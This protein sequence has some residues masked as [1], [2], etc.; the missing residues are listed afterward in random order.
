MAADDWPKL[1]CGVR[2]R[3]DVKARLRLDFVSGF[4][5]AFDHDDALQPRPIMT[6][7][8]PANVM[9]DGIVP[10]FDAPVIAI[11]GL[12]AAD[13]GIFEIVGFLLG[14]EEFHILAQGALIAF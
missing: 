8:Q 13:F 14:G 9:R 6:F 4:A 10:G 2:Q 11:H 7:L 3:G 1:F 12:M 5:R